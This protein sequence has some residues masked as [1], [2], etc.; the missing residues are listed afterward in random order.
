[1]TPLPFVSVVV[2]CLDEEPFIA[3]CLE[4]LRE[5]DYPRDRMEIL[6]VDGGSR[7]G[8]RT[9]LERVAAEDPRVRVI[10]NPQRIQACGMNAGIRAA[11]GEVIVRMDA[12]CECAGDYVRRCVEALARSGADNAGGAQRAR[13][14]SA[15]QRALCAALDSPLAVGGARYRS[16]ANEGFVDTVFLGAFPRRAFETVGLYD[17]RAVTNEDAELNE[18]IRK[19]GGRVYLSRDIVVHYFPRGSY[20]GL[21]R[22][23]FRYGMGRARTVLKHRSVSRLRSVLP[24]GLVVGGTLFLAIPALR[25]LAAWAFGGYALV[26]LAEAARVGRS[27]GGAVAARAATI[28]PVL[29]VS[30]GLGFAAGLVR[31][32][33]DS[34]WEVQDRL[35]PRKLRRAGEPR[36]AAR[37]EVESSAKA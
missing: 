5:Q 22:Q 7:D 17:P 28:F 8:T 36:K 26:A 13:A 10:D 33:V 27:G 23:Y 32:A 19:A 37:Q 3:A 25:P 11:A 2:P 9:I 4:R 14:R 15:F 16:A 35:P 24:F 1:M 21:A 31:F 29:H 20:R 30:H 12:H 34:D 6:V 18:R